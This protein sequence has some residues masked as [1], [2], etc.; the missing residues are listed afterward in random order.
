MLSQPVSAAARPHHHAM[1]NSM[2]TVRRF[3]LLLT[4]MSLICG[5]LPL[6]AE[7]E[8]VVTDIQAVKGIGRYRGPEGGKALLKKNGFVVVPDY[9]H[10][11]FS[12]YYGSPLPRFITADSLHR[13]FH[14]I[15]EDQLRKVETAFIKDLT[16]LTDALIADLT[17]RQE[18]DEQ[19]AAAV[20]YLRVARSLL[21]PA[22]GVDGDATV[23]AELDLIAG[24]GG[25]SV[26]P[27]FGYKIDYGEFKPRGFY[28]ETTALRRYFKA[29]SWYGNAAFRLKSDRETRMAVLVS[30]ALENHREALACWRKLDR[31]YTYLVAK[32]DDL[33]P[34]EYAAASHEIKH[35]TAS[36]EFLEA[37]RNKAGGMRDPK[38]NSMI[39]SPAEMANWVDHSKGMRLFGK[40][41]IPDS[42][43][44][45]ALTHPRV[46]GRGFPSGLDMMVANGSKQAEKLMSDMSDVK[47]PGYAEGMK[48]SVKL[49]NRLKAEQRPS[50]Y[51]ELLRVAETLT[52][53]PVKQAAPFARTTA[54]AEKNV[55]AALASWASLRHAWVLHAKQS[56]ICLRGVA[57]NPMPGYVEPNPAFFEAME[58]VNK[59][60]IDIFRAVSGAE[61]ERFREFGKLLVSLQEMLRRQFA[62]EEF[63]EQEIDLFER[64]ANVIGELQ[65]FEFNMDAD[66]SFPWMALICDVH[67]EVLRQQCLEVGTSGAM[68]IYV[69]VEQDGVPHLLKGA[70]YSYFEFKQPVSDRL[71]DE[72]WQ[73]RWDAGKMPA[74]QAWTASF[75]ASHDVVSLLRRAWKGEIVEALLCI[76]DSRIDSFFVEAVKPGWR[77]ALSESYPWILR[78]AARKL[79]N[80][81]AP[82]LFNILRTG[83]VGEGWEEKAADHAADALRFAVRETEL[84]ALL[85]IALGKDKQRAE[86]ALQAGC[87]LPRRLKAAFLIT[88]LATA[89]EDT[90]SR[91]CM[92]QLRYHPPSKDITGPLLACYAETE[93]PFRRRLILEVLD[94][95]WSGSGFM[96]FVPQP[97]PRASGSEI[98]A[99]E[100][101]IR[102]MVL[103]A[104]RSE[105][106]HLWTGAIRLAGSL[107]IA[108][109]VPEIAKRVTVAAF[110]KERKRNDPFAGDFVAIGSSW[111]R[112]PDEYPT[113]APE[114]L[115]RIGTDAAVDALVRLSYVR[116][117]YKKRKILEALEAVA[118]ERSAPRLAEL[119]NNTTG[120]RGYDYRI[121]DYA[122]QALTAIYPDGPALNTEKDSHAD[123]ERKIAEWKKFIAR[124]RNREE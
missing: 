8:D 65:G 101:G 69:V 18:K 74:L 62:G 3:P 12:P 7:G 92:D 2:Q 4:A 119:L 47:M 14:V 64:Y 118:S 37:F 102:K 66:K 10:R 36:P 11:I 43:I 44:F 104:L 87:R 108:E 77:L 16:L 23:A 79:G 25:I 85:N 50:H 21:A 57:S 63:N 38:V 80:E 98:E 107:R 28:T 55:M 75:A 115:A 5:P 112:E 15:F 78:S 110:D 51:I 103:D 123:R 41:Y 26:S 94:G 105:D 86:L 13:T 27:L 6:G 120:I 106:R 83:E 91:E 49:L 53:E 35:E 61:V 29:M 122:A 52:S 121:C 39:L 84:P 58:R 72:A 70:V 46:H 93:D 60:S 68:P 24:A 31:T 76:D 82:T 30:S 97:V 95:V 17:V 45:M 67:T 1:E 100:E 88:Y 71:T 9:H 34:S 99:W 54:Y 32:T 33:T 19:V 113:Y 73:S 40:R 124:K 20:Q 96:D 117:T 59:R 114:A 109:A 111:P 56:V 81:V 42:E 90:F 22:K 48:E 89:T 116:N